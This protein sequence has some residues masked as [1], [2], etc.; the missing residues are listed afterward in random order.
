MSKLLDKFLPRYFDLLASAV[1]HGDR[2]FL[3]MYRVLDRIDA[4][5]THNRLPD[6]VDCMIQVHRTRI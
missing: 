5:M 4:H 6:L 1:A 2:F 3:S